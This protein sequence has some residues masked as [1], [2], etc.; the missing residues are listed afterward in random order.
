MKTLIVQ[1]PDK[2]LAIAKEFLRDL[3]A[4]TISVKAAKPVHR[5]PNATTLKAIQDAHNGKTKKINDLEAFLKS[6]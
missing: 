3:G 5:T 2:K 6:I 1:L 4:V